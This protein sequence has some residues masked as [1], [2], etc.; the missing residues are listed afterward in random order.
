MK[1]VGT[2][3]KG[4]RQGQGAYYDYLQGFCY[5]GEWLKGK[6]EGKGCE[7][8]FDMNQTGH[9]YEGQFSKGKRHGKGQLTMHRYSYVG[10]WSNG[11]K[12][13]Y[14]V[15]KDE[16]NNE[17]YRGYF[18]NNLRKGKGQLKSLG[19]SYKIYDGDFKAGVYEGQGTIIYEGNNY[20]IGSFKNGLYHG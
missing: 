12:E 13:G 3:H 14:G 16:V 2:F 1:Y 4:H 6:Y 9:C 5:R 10:N 11:K 8:S 7:T 19:G 17:N 15:E 20:Y 18:V